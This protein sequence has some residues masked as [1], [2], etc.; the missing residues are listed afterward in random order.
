MR[1]FDDLNQLSED[2]EFDIDSYFDD[3]DLTNK[4][5]EERKDFAREMQDV[6]LFVF[7]LYLIMKQYNYENKKY[8]IQQLQKRY[9]YT[10]L[11]Y[12]EIDNY[13]DEMINDSARDI[14][15][16]TFHHDGEEYFTSDERAAL[17]ACNSANDT[18][19]YKQYAEAIKMGKKNKKWITEKDMK[20]RKTHKVLDNII[21]PIDRTFLVGNTLMRFPHDTMFGVDYEQL[22][23][24]RCTIKYF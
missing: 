6:L 11:R 3:M 17:I 18:L 14:V 2:G 23:N 21:I 1:E 24:C 8:I 7:S 13:L 15:D 19:N 4:E 22:S 5:K 9:S 20:V 12:T 16:T 10:V